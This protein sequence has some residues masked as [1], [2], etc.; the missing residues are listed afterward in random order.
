MSLIIV[1][2]T[3]DLF[4]SRGLKTSDEAIQA[5]NKEF[6]KICRK[7]ADNVE[8]NRLKTVKAAHVPDISLQLNTPTDS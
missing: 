5:L 1:K 2:K 4:K 6:E 7:A 8:A 3:K